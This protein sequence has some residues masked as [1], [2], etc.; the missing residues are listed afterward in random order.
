MMMMDLLHRP[1]VLNFRERK[2]HH[3]VH[4]KLGGGI[5]QSP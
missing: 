5:C 4:G 3:L 1:D 2:Q